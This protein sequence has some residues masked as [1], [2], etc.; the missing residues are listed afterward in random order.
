MDAAQIDDYRGLINETVT[1]FTEHNWDVELFT[2]LL[3]VKAG[4]LGEGKLR[5]SFSII[6][7]TSDMI[8]LSAAF[9]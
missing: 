7:I 8:G 3:F 4:S 6:E 5:C 9:S 1:S 2:F